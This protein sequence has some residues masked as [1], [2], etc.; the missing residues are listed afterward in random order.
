[1][2]KYRTTSQLG[3]KQLIQ[4]EDFRDKRVPGRAR[5]RTM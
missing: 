1:M 3:A 5:V 4:K 2:R